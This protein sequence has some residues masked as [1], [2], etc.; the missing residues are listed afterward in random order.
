M[1]TVSVVWVSTQWS[2]FPNPKHLKT[3]SDVL[4][5]DHTNNNNK[6]DTAGCGICVGSFYCFSVLVQTEVVKFLTHLL[7][8]T[9]SEHMILKCLK[10]C[11]RLRV[12]EGVIA[13]LV[14]PAL[15]RTC[16]HTVSLSHTHTVFTP[17]SHTFWVWLSKSL[18]VLLQVW[19]NCHPLF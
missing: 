14:T 2:Y 18:R 8:L 16:T 17:L 12:I 11:E 10:K 13:S 9:F 5:S 7:H 1:L 15:S 6:Y 3:I 19:E 4:E